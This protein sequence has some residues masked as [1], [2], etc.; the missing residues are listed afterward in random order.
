MSEK[1]CIICGRGFVPRS[2]RHL[3]CSCE[4]SKERNRRDALARYWSDREAKLAYGREY[5]A[6]NKEAMREYLKR[7]RQKIAEQKAAY[8]ERNR[9]KIAAQAKEYR[10]AHREAQT[11]QH[12]AY[13]QNNIERE[14]A[15][16]RAYRAAWYWAD[17]E[18]AREVNRVNLRK[19]YAARQLLIANQVI[20]KMKKELQN[21]HPDLFY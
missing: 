3:T 20:A 15:R 10:K 12:R 18:R 6:L 4:C 8:R 9:L 21:E 1:F 19:Y 17:P 13:Y 7:N 16:A 14:R 2:R 5:R 11:A